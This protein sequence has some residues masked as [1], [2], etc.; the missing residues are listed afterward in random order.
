VEKLNRGV[1]RRTTALLIAVLFVVS[2]FSVAFKSL[3]DEGSEPFVVKKFV[4]N[5]EAKLNIADWLVG[6]GYG[7]DAASGILADISFELYSSDEHGDQAEDAPVA[8]CGIGA[9]GTVTF[10]PEVESGWYLI[11]EVMGD[12]ARAVFLDGAPDVLVYY[13]AGP[14]FTEDT[15]FTVTQYK[16]QT[17][18]LQALYRDENGVVRSAYTSPPLDVD[19]PVPGGGALGTSRFEVT[20]DNG[21]KF[22]SFCADIGAL[23][24]YGEFVIDETNHSFTHDQMLRLIAAIDFIY[25]RSGFSQYDDIALAQ[26]VVWNMI[27]VYTNDPMTA[28]LWLLSL[29]VLLKDQWGELFKIEGISQFNGVNY[30]Y[31]QEYRDLIDDIITNADNDKYVDIYKARIGTGAGKHVS[32]AY[33]LRGDSDYPGYLQQRQLIITFG[34]SAS[35]SNIPCTPTPTPTVTPTPTPTVTPTPTPTLTPERGRL[36]VTKV[37]NIEVIPDDWSATVTVTGPNGFSASGTVTGAN[38]VFSLTDLEFGTY[39][40]TET[41]PDDIALY[42]LYSVTGEGT[43]TVSSGTTA[44]T[45]TNNYEVEEIEDVDVPQ[46]DFPIDEPDVPKSDMPKTDSG[47]NIPAYAFGLFVSFFALG[48]ALH[49]IRLATRTTRARK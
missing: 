2:M 31:V 1:T 10:P 29:G 5:G 47:E 4:D 16:D 41:D 48:I 8:T 30:W 24:C 46:G 23:Q 3:A 6:K 34:S 19:P 7:L 49:S 45:I 40:V 13:D 43:Y 15:R 11:R 35:F 37:F 38:R 9:D 25:A 33:F 44:A 20:Q 21:D 18:Q 27:L 39:T 26:L 17:R 22:T 28:D 14:A 12:E 36:E 42:A 32:G